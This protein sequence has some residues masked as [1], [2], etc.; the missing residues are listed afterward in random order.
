MARRTLGVQ[1]V[2]T[3][4]YLPRGHHVHVHVQRK[5]RPTQGQRRAAATAAAASPGNPYDSLDG[6]KVISAGTGDLVSLREQWSE[7]DTAV[8][9]FGRSFG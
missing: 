9:A 4:S 1:V 2:K 7:G 8:V 3:G 5:Q 6:I